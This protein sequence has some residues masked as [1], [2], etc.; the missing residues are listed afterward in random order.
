MVHLHAQ[1]D[2]D[3]VVER[4]A[5]FQLYLL[6]PIV[7]VVLLRAILKSRRSA[8]SD[9]S[10]DR[11]RTVRWI[12]L[13]NYGLS[14]RDLL[15]AIPELVAYQQFGG[16]SSFP[17]TNLFFPII[18]VATNLLMGWGVRGFRPWARWLEVAFNLII[19]PFIF[20]A[21]WTSTY[22]AAIDPASWP[23]LA[24]SYVLPFFLIF[25][26]VLPG[27]KR[28]FS[29]SGRAARAEAQSKDRGVARMSGVAATALGFLTTLSAVL[30]VNALYW[31]M[32]Y[33]SAMIEGSQP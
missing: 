26:M 12:G 10:L 13:L 27:T 32:F 4:I 22:G 14:V 6:P 20:L 15:L 8:V 31:L 1:L 21:A 16:F 29:A 28:A 11:E 5:Q 33:G 9:P 25:V 3:L 18:A 7:A 30:L 24:I 23:D 19:V 17:V 2:M